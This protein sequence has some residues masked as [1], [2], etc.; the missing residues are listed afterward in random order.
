MTTETPP[1]AHFAKAKRPLP[2]LWIGAAALVVVAAALGAWWYFWGF[3]FDFMKPRAEHLDV[4]APATIPYKPE[5]GPECKIFG[6]LQAG[7]GAPHGAEGGLE[8]RYDPSVNDAIAQWGDCLDSIFVCLNAT[9]DRTPARV[10]DCVR[11]AKCPKECKDRYAARSVST[12]EEAEAAFFG[13]F[14][15]KDAPCRPA[16][17]VQGAVA[18][19]VPETPPPGGTP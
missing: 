18:G 16:D 6:T 17:S 1:P 15:D 11:D 4:C 10:N 14:V 13:I 9:A 19:E 7:H 8:L 12:I 2:L 5:C 3:G